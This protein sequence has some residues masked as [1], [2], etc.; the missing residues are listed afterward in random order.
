MQEYELCA[1]FGADQA[2]EQIDEHAQAIEKLLTEANAEIKF[3][4]SLGRKKLAYTISGQTNG[5]YRVWLF[6][7]EAE[8]IPNLNEKLR[9]SQFVLRHLI[10]RLEQVSI[11]QR[12]KT[13]EEAKTPKPKE[14]ERVE[15]EEV[16]KPAPSA[17]LEPESKRDEKKAGI[18]ELDKKLDE[19][20]ESDKI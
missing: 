6:T 7:V 4:H 15:A 9:L 17:P 2:Q 8:A 13:L 18:E 12:T 16:E 3:A 10:T 19:L 5:E 20:L 1:L 14:E 11:E